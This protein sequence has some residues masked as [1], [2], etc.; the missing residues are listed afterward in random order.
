MRNSSQPTCWLSTLPSVRRII[1]RAG[2]LQGGGGGG[3]GGVAAAMSGAGTWGIMRLPALAM[4]VAML[5]PPFMRTCSQRHSIWRQLWSAHTTQ[6]PA[7]GRSALCSVLHP[8]SHYFASHTTQ[9]AITHHLCQRLVECRP[10]AQVSQLQ[11][12]ARLVAELHHPHLA[13][14]A[15]RRAQ[16]ADQRLPAAPA[17][18]HTRGAGRAPCPRARARP[19]P[20][21]RTARAPTPPQ[22][23]A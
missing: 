19:A 14:A 23:R 7:Q 15:Q 1:K 20:S 18:R 22:T 5:V 13:G 21:A 17:A 3:G 12:R 4:A 16:H 11:L 10:I 8:S 6:L 2:T 9:P